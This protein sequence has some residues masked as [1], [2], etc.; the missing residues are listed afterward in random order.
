MTSFG[1]QIGWMKVKKFLNLEEVFTVILIIKKK[2][3]SH[4]MA[5]IS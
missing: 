2:L 3:K 5:N 1:L 4:G